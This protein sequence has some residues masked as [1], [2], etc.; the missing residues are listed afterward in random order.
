MAQ[1]RTAVQRGTWGDLAVVGAPLA[2]LYA[3][4]CA[5]DLG[6][7]DSG[8]LA[9]VCARGG[10]AHPTGYALYSLL[11]RLAVMLLPGSPIRAVN[12]LS[13]GVAVVAALAVTVLARQVLR[14]SGD[15]DAAA[16]WPARGAGLIWGTSEVFWDQ[17]TGNEVYGLHLLYVA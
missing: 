13:L 8:E 5:R 1:G 17:A 3:A 7:I 16:A 4:T 2:V 15:S 9:L 14:P 6:T 11:G 12:L 10:V